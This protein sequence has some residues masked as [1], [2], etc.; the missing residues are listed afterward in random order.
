MTAPRI[1][2]GID[3]G[4][5]RV[6]W[7]VATAAAGGGLERLAS[8]AWML[9][10]SPLPMPERL[11]LLHGYV[12]A[13]LAEWRPAA[14]GLEAAFFGQNARS[15]L[16]LGEARGVILLSCGA[17]G[18]PVRELPPA[19]VKRRVAGAGAATKEQLAE[20]VRT[21]F[22][23]PDHHFAAEDE[24]D[25]LAVA[26]CLLLEEGVTRALDAPAVTPARGARRG[27]ALPPGAVEQ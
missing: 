11:H 23:I 7:A 24:S 13:L 20:L 21:Q 8:G 4:S 15:A 5:Q 26:A 12:E 6:G 16:R 9:G 25:A 17:H 22:G 14:V 3:P 2:V 1:V 10:R 27:G 18:V 19:T